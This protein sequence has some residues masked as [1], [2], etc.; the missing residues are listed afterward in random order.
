[1]TS[2]QCSWWGS[3]RLHFNHIRTFSN[4]KLSALKT[5]NSLSPTQNSVTLYSNHMTLLES[6]KISRKHVK[7]PL[8]KKTHFVRRRKLPKRS[9]ISF[10]IL[11][12]CL[13]IT[14]HKKTNQNTKK[15]E[16]KLRE[17]R[18]GNIIT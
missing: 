15:K 14:K 10:N 7:N 16:R 3:R 4:T 13:W 17:K 5:Q 6:F 18:P 1:V 12:C 11:F 9:F 8:K 2:S